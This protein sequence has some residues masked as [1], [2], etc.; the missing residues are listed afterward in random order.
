[1]PLSTQYAHMLGLLNERAD[2]LSEPEKEV[3]AL[4]LQLDAENRSST[5]IEHELIQTHW[6]RLIRPADRDPRE[7]MTVNEIWDG[8]YE[9][10]E[11]VQAG[12]DQLWEERK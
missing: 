4:L 9:I 11:G 1:M 3:H 5:A 6:R 2:S 12:L 8:Q 7:F 10:G